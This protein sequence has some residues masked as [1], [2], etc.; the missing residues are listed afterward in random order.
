MEVAIVIFTSSIILPLFIPLS[1]CLQMVFTRLGSLSG[2]RVAWT[3]VRMVWVLRALAFVELLFLSIHFY[4]DMV[5]TLQRISCNLG[6]VPP[7]PHCIAA[8]LFPLD[9]WDNPPPPPGNAVIPF[10]AGWFNG[11][12]S[13]K[14]QHGHVSFWFNGTIFVFTSRSVFTLGN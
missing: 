4:W 8:T 7:C 12:R 14:W 10:F 2:V 9:N 5:E 1:C 13:P 3:L 11:M 6:Y